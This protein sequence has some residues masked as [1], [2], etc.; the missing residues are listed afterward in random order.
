MAELWSEAADLLERT[1]TAQSL[2]IEYRTGSSEAAKDAAWLAVPTVVAGLR[3]RAENSAGILGLMGTLRTFDYSELDSPALFSPRSQRSARASDLAHQVFGSAHAEVVAAIADQS[4][5]QLTSADG[6]LGSAAW[7]MFATIAERH[8]ERLD[9]QTL[10]ALLRG[11]QAELEAQGWSDWLASLDLELGAEAETFAEPAPLNPIVAELAEVSRLGETTISSADLM[12]SASDNPRPAVPPSRPPSRPGPKQFPPPV[13]SPERSVK[14]PAAP[15]YR[16]TY[17]D[18]PSISRG[19]GTGYPPPRRAEAPATDPGRRALPPP[20]R[21]TDDGNRRRLAG[22]P[23]AG[24]ARQITGYPYER[25]LDYEPSAPETIERKRRWIPAL[26]GALA[27]LVLGGIAYYYLTNSNTTDDQTATE[28]SSTDESAG[29]TSTTQP[30]T[31]AEVSP[32]DRVFTQPISL[33]VPMTDIFTDTGHSGLAD[34]DLNPSTGEICYDVTTDGVGEPYD[35]H[36]HTG[37]INIKG[38]IVVDFGNFTNPETGCYQGRPVD[39]QAIMASLDTFYVEMHDVNGESAVRGQLSSGLKPEDEALLAEGA[40]TNGAMVFDPEGGGASALIEDGQVVLTGEVA[41]QATMDLLLEQFADLPDN[42]TSVVNNLTLNPAAPLPAG[43][44]DVDDAIFFGIGSAL[45]NSGDTT[46][47][48][49][50]ATVF[51]ARPEWTIL[52]RGHTDN[53]GTDV[54][55]LELS[56]QRA[57]AV[58]DAL[59][60]LGVPAESMRTEGA[61]STDP[62]ASNDTEEGR[63]ENRRIEFEISA[64]Q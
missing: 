6:I 46:I 32:T 45:L 21:P 17:T 20:V 3:S 62:I 41:D 54:I 22:A 4:R 9:R 37:E 31:A 24:G 8:G 60:E 43:T 56:Q 58:L 61:G 13:R 63:A 5:V 42:G 38:G 15:A 29:P 16:P 1:S 59:A 25:P 48:E 50:L 26:M 7:I 12:A 30:M 49:D 36:I 47:L 44:I 53:T 14:P 23:P 28:A 39:V 40:Q 33:S 10:I 34:L 51:K 27:V 57:N 18:R 64:T 11:E 55:N 2:A 35:A 52:I 19:S